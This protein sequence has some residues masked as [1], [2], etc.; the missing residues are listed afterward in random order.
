MPAGLAVVLQQRSR[1]K[2]GYTGRRNDDQ[3]QQRIREFV[4]SFLQ[5][6]LRLPLLMNASF[7]NFGGSCLLT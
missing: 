4:L 7:G 5:Q 3:L 6:T 2:Y 1:G